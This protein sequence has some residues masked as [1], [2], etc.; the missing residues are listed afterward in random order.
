MR[1]GGRSCARILIFRRYLV[2]GDQSRPRI[3]DEPGFCY[4]GLS[5]GVQ[6]GRS[7]FSFVRRFVS[8][9]SRVASILV[10]GFPA[11]EHVYPTLPVVAELGARGHRV[12]YYTSE[13]FFDDVAFYRHAIEAYSGRD[14][15]QAV[16]SIGGLDPADLGRTLR[17]AGGFRRAADEI[18]VA[19]GVT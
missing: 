18:E 13:R 4:R 15:M 5:G 1:S 17:A 19:I 9:V 7:F 10:F 16:L 12:V 2:R 11:H 14:D 8:E 6:A 3:L